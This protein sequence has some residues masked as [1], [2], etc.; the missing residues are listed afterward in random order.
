MCRWRRSPGRWH[1]G[2][3]GADRDH[4]V[5]AG[6]GRLDDHRREARAD[7]RSAAKRLRSVASSTA[8]GRSSPRLAPSLSVLL[9]WDGPVLEGLGAALILPAIVALVAPT[10]SRDSDR[11]RTDWSP[12]PARSRSQRARSS[13]GCSRPISLGGGCYVGEVLSCGDSCARPPDGMRSHL[14]S[15]ARARLVGIVLSALGLGLSVF[16]SPASGNVGV[17][18][19][20]RRVHPNWSACRRQSGCSRRRL[21][22]SAGLRVVG[23]PPMTSHVAVSRSSIRAIYA[24]PAASAGSRSFLFQFLLQGGLFFTVPLFLSVA[25]GL[26]RDSIRAS[27]SC[28]S[29]SHC[30]SPRWAFRSC[31]RTRHHGGSWR[32]G[33]A[34]RCSP[35]LS[36]WSPA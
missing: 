11:V 28:R 6:D 25:L 22:V 10:S 18:C 26:S 30:S 8:A 32:T 16:A 14:R 7:A 5:H 2:H 29:R 19:A 3:R 27:G 24:S 20:R 9:I 35:A 4:A 23:V 21:V 1:H 13:A 15:G 12:P 17:G 31:C 34:S 33:L 36:C